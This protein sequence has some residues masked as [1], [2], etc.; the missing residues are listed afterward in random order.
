M[1]FV[2]GLPR[3]QTDHDAIWVIMDK[4][5]KLAHFLAIHSTFFLERLA[6]LYS[7]KIVQLHEVPVS[8]MS[9]RDPRFTSRSWSRL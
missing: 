3:T 4:L 6:K 8:I 5:T 2:V 1:D 9:D 7:N